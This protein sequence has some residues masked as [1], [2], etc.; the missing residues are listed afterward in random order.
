MID[1]DFAVLRFTMD[2]TQ[3]LLAVVPRHNN[4]TLVLYSNISR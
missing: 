1:F 4:T 3:N 2:A